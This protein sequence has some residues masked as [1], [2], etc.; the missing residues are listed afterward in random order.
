MKA[1]G[2]E[3]TAKDLMQK[4]SSSTTLQRLA[5]SLLTIMTGTPVASS[6]SDTATGSAGRVQVCS[7]LNGYAEAKRNAQAHVSGRS[8]QAVSS[9]RCCKACCARG[10]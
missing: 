7:A 6:L 1:A 10:Q 5:G 9:V 2:V 3:G 8:S 4:P